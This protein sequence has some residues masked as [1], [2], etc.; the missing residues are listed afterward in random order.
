MQNHFGIGIDPINGLAG[1]LGFGPAHVRGAV[2]DL[3]LQIGKIHG[4]EIQ[5]TQ[6]A[7]SGRGQVHRDGRT[8]AA[9]AN[10]K[11]AGGTDFLLT[12]QAHFRQDQVSRVAANFVIV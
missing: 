4:I 6:L 5:H 11:D 3:P 8:E 10:A 9:G 12:S 2:D 7:D 1:G